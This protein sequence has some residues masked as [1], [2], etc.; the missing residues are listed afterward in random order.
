MNVRSFDYR[1]QLT[2]IRGEI[3]AAIAAVLDSGTLVLGE[4]VQRF[5]REFAAWLGGGHA[6]G[7]NSGTDALVIAL[8]ALGV[9]P[10]DEVVTVPNTA[11]PTVSAI[12]MTGATP[13]FCDV[14]PATALLDLAQLPR[15]LTGR[16]RAIVPVHLYG[17][18]V[19]VAALMAMVAGRGIAVVEDCAQSHGAR[20]RG[21]HAGTFGDAAAFSFYPTKNL[22]AYGDGGLCFA[23]DAALAD[24]MRRIRMY[25]FADAYYA[26]REGRNSRLDEL[27]AAI[28]SVKLRHLDGW[29]ERRRTLAQRY[30][31]RLAP[32]IARVQTA[33]GVEP[34]R[35]LYVVR[36][37]QRDELR[38]RLGDL[39]VATGVHY[40]TPIHR[41]R[42]YAFLGC[43]DGHAPVAERL[44][45]EVLSLPLYPELTDAEV[46]RVVTALH[47]LV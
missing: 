10:G 43:A 40:P 30:D 18:V 38:R 45:R 21:R 5:E 7:V 23:R 47:S 4:A 32:T 46:D 37:P 19:D 44:A 42:G 35:H 29:V 24:Q 39:G 26:E 12:R 8:L 28:L 16:T 6:V 11:V 9:G 1:A 15:H 33:A 2:G 41:M 3:D 22:G 17:N 20:L 31:E 14:D 34:A 27:Q 13:V 36:V 25:G